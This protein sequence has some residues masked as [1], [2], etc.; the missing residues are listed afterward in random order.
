MKPKLIAFL[1]S[2]M[3]SVS[4][5]EIRFIEIARR[6][7]D[8]D[9]IIVT[10]LLGKRLC[11]ERELDA[12]YLITTREKNVKNVLL[13][14]CKRIIRA[15]RLKI[16][17]N[18][19]DVLFSA[20]DFLPDIIPPFILKLRNKSVGWVVSVYHL[21]PSPLKRPK[22]LALTNVLSYFGQRVSLMLISRYADIVNTEVTYVK[23][24][25]SQE[26]KISPER[27]VV[28]SGG[29]NSACIDEVKFRGR[30]KYDACFLS[31]LH[32]S[33]GVV[34]LVE[35]WKIVC[36]Y[37]KDAKLAITGNVLL[38]GAEK[39]VKELENGIIEAGLKNNIDMLGFLSEEEKYRTLKTSKMLLH[40]SYEEGIPIVFYEAMYCGLPVITYYLP[41]Y[42]DI[43][44]YIVK[45]PLGNI[46]ALAG[47]IIRILENDNLLCNLSNR[48]KKLA[49]EHTWDKV[50]DNII[51]Q[52]DSLTNVT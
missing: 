19:G 41:P 33:K 5:G 44:D 29:I 26:F 17:T 27:I 1:N 21:I 12:K 38:T 30:K 3:E 9:K 13:T 24:R 25:L 6:V 15:L 47:E 46:K 18:R 43:K 45:V 51:S 37:K 4:G 16:R 42:A 7:D 36:N 49:E 28:A 10:S 48:G 31:R 39:Y 50:A 11:E 34:D 23:E 32:P 35:A 8:F 52:I 20:S 14:Y 22:G 40:P 2:Y